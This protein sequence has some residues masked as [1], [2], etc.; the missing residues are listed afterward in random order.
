MIPS[1]TSLKTLSSSRFRILK[2]LGQ[3]SFGTAFLVEA[4]VSFINS[5]YVIKKIDI[6]KLDNKSRSAALGEVEEC[7][8]QRHGQRLGAH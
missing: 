8:G 1:N 7:F 2:V 5:K 4:L 6:S 3:G